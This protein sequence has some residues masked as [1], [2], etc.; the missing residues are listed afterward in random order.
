MRFS[1]ASSEKFFEIAYNA[2]NLYGFR[3]A[4]LVF[5]KHKQ[6]RSKKINSYNK[7]KDKDLNNLSSLLK[8]FLERDIRVTDEPIFVFHSNID[9]D[10]RSAI[11]ASKKPEN[12]YFT[13]SIIGLEGPYAEA[14]LLSCTNYIFNKLESKNQ[15]VRINSMGS[16]DDSKEYFTRLK[17]TLKKMKKDI[18]PECKRLLDDAKIAEAHILLYGDDSNDVSDYIV[19]TLRLLSD[20]ARLHFEKLIEYIEEHGLS[21]ELA[22]DLVEY[23]HYG[24]H[25]VF[26]MLS[27][28]FPFYARGGR[29]DSLSYHMYR[30]NIP[31]T[32][33]TITLPEKTTG[34][35]T[36][37]QQIDDPDIFFLH[38]G[39]KARLRSLH[40]LS[41]LCNENIC[42]A[43]QLHQ[44]RVCDQI[45]I[46]EKS[47]PYTIIF[48]Q[49][50]AENNVICLRKADTKI[51][52]TVD[53]HSLKDIK[54]FL[55]KKKSASPK[56]TRKSKK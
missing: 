29:Y 44:S 27:E 16:R 23:T 46:Q 34:T 19:P 2:A 42:V 4:H 6:Q 14:L 22:P 37:K 30:R 1:D 49:E 53:I 45:D 39:T 41:Q 35:H 10:T 51:S 12:A 31:I 8:F 3:P 56:R 32:S 24:A 48:G 11:T 25:T 26:E 50:E 15:L 40:V 17:R 28:D 33:I 18:Q 52:S 5:E 21:Y 54:K 36:T 13:L 38:A 7:V 55:Q 9:K 47:Y 43:H 20:N